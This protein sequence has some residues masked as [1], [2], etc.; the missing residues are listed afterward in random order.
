MIINNSIKYYIFAISLILFQFAGYTPYTLPLLALAAILLFS[1]DTFIYQ[2]RTIPV[3]SLFLGISLLIGIANVIFRDTTSKSIMM[4]GQFYFF[5]FFF[6][7]TQHKTELI[8]IIKAVVYLIFIADILSNI[9]LAMG[10]SLPW[11]AF[12][13][14]RPG[15]FLPR[16]PGVKSNTLYSGSISFLAICC[17]LHEDIKNKWIKRFIMASML[18]NLLLAGSFRYYIIL[19]A[20]F[21]L[22]KYQFFK[23]PRLLKSLYFLL[24]IA[25]VIMT[26]LTVDISQSNELRWALWER[27]VGL[28]LQSPL[29]GIGFFFQTLKDNT[30]FTFHNLAMAGVTESTILLIALC[31][32]IPVMLLF[33]YAIYKT[34]T[35]YSTYKEYSIELGLFL[36]LSLDLFW[37]GSL[38]NC[39]SLSI[40][41]LSLGL[42]NY[43]GYIVTQAGKYIKK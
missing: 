15:E 3:F 5:A 30:I 16:F 35:Y 43:H 27:T 39:I 40:L 34:L 6:I 10:F 33:L 4:W 24:V 26:A 22:Y 12:P 9:L 8:S 17:F 38:D 21:L 1:V 13:P 29:T 20:V 28:I 32:G 7:G 11:T 42:I 18:I 37:G 2:I 25:V 41:L 36:G 14:I 19:L 31:F 23:H